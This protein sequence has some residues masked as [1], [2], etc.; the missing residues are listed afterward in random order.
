MGSIYDKATH[1]ATKLTYCKAISNREDAVLQG[2]LR[3]EN[4]LLLDP[5]SDLE[6]MATE[7]IEP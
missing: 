1:T 6:T 4:K 2:H 5:T 3:S 7:M